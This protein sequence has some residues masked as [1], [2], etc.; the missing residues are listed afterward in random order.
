[1][2]PSSPS[3]TRRSLLAASAATGALSLLPAMARASVDSE[4]VRPFRAG[5]PEEAIVD[6]RRRLATTRWPLRETVTDQSQG[7][8]LAKLQ[9]LLRY[10]M[11]DYNW[12]KVEAKLNAL[13]MF[14]TEIDGLAIHF[15]HVR[16][17]H[18]N[19]IPMIMTHGWPG[20]ILEFMKVVGPLTDPTAHGGAAEDA[21]HLV[22]PSIPGFGFSG[23]P[24]EAGWGSD[25]IGRAWGVLMR[26]L[27]Y[28]RY[29]SQGGDCGSVISHRMALQ[30]VPGLI[31]IHVNMPGTVPPEIASVLAAG[32]PTP[33]GLTEKESAAFDALDTFYK[34]SSGY[35]AM[36]V[37]RPQTIG[38]SLVDSPVGLAAWIYEKFAQWTYSGGDPER[39]LTKD[40]ML[41]DISLYWLTESGTSAAQIYW[42][43]HS[44]NFNAVD[45]ADLPVAVTVFPG[46]IYCAPR[47]WAERCYH[48]LIYF[49]E[50]KAGGHFAAWEQ[51]EI[52]TQEVRAAFKSL[53]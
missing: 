37:T 36:M 46:E 19:A 39:V 30:K 25:H 27:G 42:E 6:L 31:G 44:N 53:R 29:V 48:N 45:I 33:S 12:R 40:E 11:T 32:G 1:M 21:F 8:Q 14:V 51:P 3:L 50:A 16:S 28:D 47:S 20:S 4:A 9:D 7:V 10:W 17:R 43:D 15:I 49:H 52:F 23:K 41:D 2:P 34:D 22:V 35:A 18:E 5:I 24:T 26:R 13:P 38:Y